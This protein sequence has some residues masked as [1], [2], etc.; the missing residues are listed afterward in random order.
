MG[1]G[2]QMGFR[3][4]P[5]GRMERA[6]ARGL[7]SRLFG[8]KQILPQASGM[9]KGELYHRKWGGVPLKA[10]EGQGMPVSLVARRME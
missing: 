5:Q 1:R 7:I 9:S 8:R 3:L 6:V 2:S 4:K 10:F